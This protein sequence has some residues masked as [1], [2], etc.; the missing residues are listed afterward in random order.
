MLV[1]KLRIEMQNNPTA[2]TM[3]LNNHTSI[4][5]LNLTATT[6]GLKQK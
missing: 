5:H 6:L 3:E 2:C 4:L 1:H